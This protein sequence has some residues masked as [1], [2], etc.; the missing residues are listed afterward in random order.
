MTA[1]TRSR[2][3]CST[4]GTAA[5]AAATARA[6]VA[7]ALI[8]H[9]RFRHTLGDPPVPAAAPE[10]PARWQ[11]LPAEVVEVVAGHLDKA[12]DLLALASV[13]RDARWEGR[14]CTQLWEEGGGT[15]HRQLA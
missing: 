6:A 3:C 1:R 14:R 13:C 2:A 15:Q 12:Q 9:P 11:D 4:S 5:A 8:V 7:H 10:P